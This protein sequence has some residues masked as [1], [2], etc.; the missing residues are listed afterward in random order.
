MLDR[1]RWARHGWAGSLLFAVSCLALCLIGYDPADP[2][3]S[4]ASPANDPTANP[5]GPV[6]AAIAHVLFTS[7][8]WASFL[9]LY[10][11]LVADWLL[12]RRRKC[13]KTSL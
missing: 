2:P 10:A 1:R 4:A 9:V 12:H 5:C 7:V 11:L 3:G 6:G 13:H 8:G